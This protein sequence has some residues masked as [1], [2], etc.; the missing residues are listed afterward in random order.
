VTVQTLRN[1][2]PFTLPRVNLLPPEIFQAAR[3]R[4]VQLAMG[5]GV[6]AA[7]AVVGILFVNELG[8]VAQAQTTLQS[9]QAQDLGLQSQ[10]NELQPL[11]AT[12]D[13][14]A[15]QK[16]LL[17]Q[18]MGS[19]IRWSFYLNDL[20]LR[21]PP[22]V[23]LTT[24]TVSQTDSPGS[25]APT[26]AAVGAATSGAQVGTISFTG[27]ALSQDD[28]AKWLTAIAAERGW[29]NPY[30][31]S[32]TETDIGSRTVYDWTGSVQLDTAALSNRYAQAGS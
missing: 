29:V 6:M 15:A 20:S 26:T 32:I 25:A 27:V 21:I 2:A 5:A 22:N 14:V 7:A 31:T 17:S 18:A 3:F 4:R 28:V 8:Q 10:I 30:V 16:A 13:S 19:E 12:Y 23:W 24:M 11:S 1:D 9:I